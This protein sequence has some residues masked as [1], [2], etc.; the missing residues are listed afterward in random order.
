[1]NELSQNN[2]IED[3]IEEEL[4]EYADIYSS[5]KRNRAKSLHARKA[6]L[7]KHASNVRYV[8]GK[9]IQSTQKEYFA[10]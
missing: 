8:C 4:L 1:M 10:N 5:K 7:V 2:D 9:C 6:K 3:V